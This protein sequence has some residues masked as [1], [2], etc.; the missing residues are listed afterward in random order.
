ME[1]EGSCPA[2]RWHS[3][4]HVAAREEVLNK[5]MNGTRVSE[6]GERHLKN[7]S[8]RNSGS[9]LLTRAQKQ[10]SRPSVSKNEDTS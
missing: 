4:R 2:S 8:G 5:E 9:I 10:D 7:P 1:A 6:A 3:L